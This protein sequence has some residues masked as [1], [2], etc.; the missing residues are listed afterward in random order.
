[1]NFPAPKPQAKPGWFRTGRSISPHLTPLPSSFSPWRK[2]TTA[3]R[4]FTAIFLPSQK[5]PSSVRSARCGSAWSLP[6]TKLHNRMKQ[7]L[8]PKKVNLSGGLWGGCGAQ[9]YALI[10]PSQGDRLVRVFIFLRR[11]LL[12]GNEGNTECTRTLANDPRFFY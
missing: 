4:S 1:M 9:L 5:T 7:A 12:E 8:N 10:C 11:R 2:S 3:G 6:A